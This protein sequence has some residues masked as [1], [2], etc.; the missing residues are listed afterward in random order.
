MIKKTL[1]L[2]LIPLFIS[3]SLFSQQ[4]SPNLQQLEKNL[5]QA[6]T[7][8][9]QASL[10]I[11]EYDTLMKTYNDGFSGVVVDAQGHILSAAHAV[12]PNKQYRVTFPDGRQFKAIG[13][14]TIPKLD[15][16]MLQITD[17]GTWPYAEMGWS[18]S[19]KPFV[20]CV[21]ISHPGSLFAYAKGPTVRFGYVADTIG[22]KN[23]SPYLRSTCLMEPG[24]SGGP[25]FDFLGRVISL[26]SRV[27]VSLNENYEVPV[28]NYRKYW[29][30][31]LL[32][33]RYNE[34][35]QEQPIPP[36]PLAL[37]IKPLPAL[38]QLDNGKGLKY[39]FKKETKAIYRLRSNIGSSDTA[40]TATLLNL[41][42]I[43]PYAQLKGKSYLISKSSMLGNEP[44]VNLAAGKTS[45]GKVIK[46]DKANDLALIVLDTLLKEGIIL[47][48]NKIS[49]PAIGSLLVSLLPAEKR[50]LSVS[51]NLPLALKKGTIDNYNL[52]I[53][54][55]DG[56]LRLLML[57]MSSPLKAAK[58]RK[59]D[60]LRAINKQTL[61]SVAMLKEV[62]ASYKPGDSVSIDYVR[63]GQPLTK[64]IMLAKVISTSTPPTE[65]SSSF[66]G[67]HMA[68]YFEGGKS[69]RREGFDQVWVHD[70]IIKP[71]ECGTP[72]FGIDGQCY[73]INIAR[74]SRTSTLAIP[75]NVVLE[76]VKTAFGTH[77]N[78]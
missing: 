72:L 12:T 44:L 49:P 52:F 74:L 3:V 17:K 45:K 16:A 71:E 61:G 63:E 26:H 14:G 34:L 10:L 69:G 19:L 43:L 28:N 1:L 25:T 42:G 27:G 9:Y 62:L 11:A 73:G 8:A 18:S 65:N 37:A 38:Q 13:L 64:K 24:D 59:G 47:P 35:P 20:P 7:K 67:F 57:D 56:K 55:D 50:V 36:D 23:Y 4:L 78:K 2:F 66:K 39:L 5:Q 51:G 75:A 76:F 53:T 32:A 22:E 21:S 6:I 70:G 46:R 40:I 58:L 77:Q 30:A 29:N 41:S 54:G 31:L 15:V 60:E 48:Q 68:E 33:K